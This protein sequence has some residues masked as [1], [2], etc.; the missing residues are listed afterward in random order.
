MQ[1]SIRLRDTKQMMNPQLVLI[2]IVL[3][4]IENIFW[5]LAWVTYFSCRK[6]LA[7]RR[8][9]CNSAVACSP[10]S[11]PL[12][13]LIHKFRL[14]S[15]KHSGLSNKNAMLLIQ[16]ISHILCLTWLSQHWRSHLHMKA[17]DI[18]EVEELSQHLAAHQ[19]TEPAAGLSLPVSKFCVLPAGL[20][21]VP[22]RVSPTVRIFYLT[23]LHLSSHTF[24]QW[25]IDSFTVCR[26]WRNVEQTGEHLAVHRGAHKGQ[27]LRGTEN[28]LFKLA[29]LCRH[30]TIHL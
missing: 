14:Q 2:S 10:E 6:T 19:M 23:P 18:P 16:N 29:G 11:K 15:H 20:H 17:W 8:P 4:S 28:A 30:E 22:I 25:F 27:R 5:S 26:T 12:N 13:S 21:Y 3:I 9:G 24:I 1:E 7:S